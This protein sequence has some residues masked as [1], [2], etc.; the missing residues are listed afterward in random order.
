MPVLAVFVCMC[1][2]SIVLRFAADA[3]HVWPAGVM[4]RALACDWR[5]RE[6]NS[7]TIRC[8][9]TTLGKLFTH[10]CLC[11]QAV[12]FCT[13]RGAAMCYDREGNHR[14]GV[15][16]AMRRRLEWFIHLQAQGLN[17][18]D[19]HPTNTPC[20]VWYS[21]PFTFICACYQILTAVITFRVSRR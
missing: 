12:K 13:S 15:R 19:E 4:V 6:F 21:L 18:E 20:G 14:S 2:A 16:L 17:K 3:S 9:V 5:G 10:M 8:Q 1:K 7:R 11:H